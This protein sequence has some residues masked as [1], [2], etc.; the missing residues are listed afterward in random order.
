MHIPNLR[1]GE[2]LTNAQFRGGFFFGGWDF[3]N[4]WIMG[5]NYPELRRPPREDFDYMDILGFVMPPEPPDSTSGNLLADLTPFVTAKISEMFGVNQSHLTTAN[6][7]DIGRGILDSILNNRH[8]EVHNIP[9]R[10]NEMYVRARMI[11]DAF[12]LFAIGEMQ[13]MSHQQILNQVSDED[14]RFLLSY[15]MASITPILVGRNAPLS[16]TETVMLLSQAM[17]TESFATVA[18]IIKKI[19]AFLAATVTTISMTAHLFVESAKRLIQQGQ[20]LLTKIMR[21]ENLRQSIINGLNSAP[22][23]LKKNPI[24]GKMEPYLKQFQFHEN[25]KAVLRRDIGGFAHGDLNHW[26]L[27]I[28]TIGGRVKY[29]LHIYV[30]DLGNVTNIIGNAPNR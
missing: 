26:N 25:Y 14:Q 13:G 8:P 4:I 5:S 10:N 7:S 9:L 28:Q 20:L 30:D 27:E 16:S 15:A 24:T 3:A 29:N 22:V 1:P 18:P 23:Q 2:G 17:T 21:G 6:H 19:K 12:F 11:T